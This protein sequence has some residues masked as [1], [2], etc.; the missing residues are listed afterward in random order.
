MRLLN[1]PAGKG[2]LLSEPRW[3]FLHQV[4]DNKHIGFF[5]CK[6]YL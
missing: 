6:R 1:I 4:I 3:R 5:Q 2:D